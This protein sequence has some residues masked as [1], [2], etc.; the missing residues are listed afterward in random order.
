MLLEHI[1]LKKNITY[2]FA[3]EVLAG[4][5]IILDEE[6]RAARM[7]HGNEHRNNLDASF[8]EKEDQGDDNP[9]QTSTVLNLTNITEM[10]R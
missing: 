5:N 6:R 10:L 1:K 9:E 8:Y 7:A 2:G 4:Y 3:R